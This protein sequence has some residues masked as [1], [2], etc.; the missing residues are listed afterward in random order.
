MSMETYE[1][2]M[3]MNDTYQRLGKGENSIQKDETEDGFR[4]LR[5]TRA[6]YGL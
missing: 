2:L 1:R 5:D 6:K 3:F 4:A